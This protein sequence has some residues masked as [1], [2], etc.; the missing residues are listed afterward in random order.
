[1]VAPVY[2]WVYE[3]PFHLISLGTTTAVSLFSNVLLLYIIFTTPSTSIG[4]YRYLL[5][6]FAICDVI[7]SFA[8]AALQPVGPSKYTEKFHSYLAMPSDSKRT[9][10]LLATRGRHDRCM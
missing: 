2:A 5:A 4:P 8:H 3:A 1:M 7:T 6:V 9:L 10:L